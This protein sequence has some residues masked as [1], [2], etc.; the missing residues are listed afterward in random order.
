MGRRTWVKIY[1]DKWLRGTIR[2]EPPEIRGIWIDLL[3]L[4]GDSA[5]G[6]EGII[7]LAPGCGLTDEQIC[8]ILNI[9]NELWQRAKQRLIE[10][11]RIKV[12]DNNEIIILNWLKYQSEYMRQKKY[13]EKLQ[14][15][16]TN[17]SYNDK[18]QN[19]VTSKSNR[20]KEKEKEK[21]NINNNTHSIIEQEKSIDFIIV[22]DEILKL[23]HELGFPRKTLRSKTD[24]E[25]LNE[26]LIKCENDW[27]KVKAGLEHIVK[28]KDRIMLFANGF[29]G[30]WAIAKNWDW[31]V[32]VKEPIKVDFGKITTIESFVR[33]LIKNKVPRPQWF[34]LVKQWRKYWG[35]KESSEQLMD[36]VEKMIKKGGNDGQIKK[37]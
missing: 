18:L 1:A 32:N 3:T 27:L 12:T 14:S 7:R 35:W 36:M 26:I 24:Q 11:E 20:E 30:L 15:K 2:E 34:S 33:F 23:L 37:T 28:H 19:K 9:D 21:E 4:A 31:L 5:Y 13:R 8:V 25:A 17:E 29:P 16:V 10:T 6:D 22:K